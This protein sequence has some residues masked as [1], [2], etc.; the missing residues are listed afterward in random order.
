MLGCF[1][2]F[3]VETWIFSFDLWTH[4]KANAYL[5]DFRLWNKKVW[6]QRMRIK[7]TGQ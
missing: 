4:P 5:W 7:G 1:F 2:F 6:H 3:P